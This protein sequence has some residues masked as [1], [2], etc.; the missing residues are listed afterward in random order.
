MPKYS[1]LTDWWFSGFTLFSGLQLL[2]PFLIRM[3]TIPGFPVGFPAGW[4]LSF[5]EQLLLGKS[6]AFQEAALSL[7][8]LAPA[9]SPV[10]PSSFQ[11]RIYLESKNSLPAV[12]FCFQGPF[13]CVLLACWFWLPGDTSLVFSSF[14]FPMLLAQI[15]SW[16]TSGYRILLPLPSMSLEEYWNYRCVLPSPAFCVFLRIWT[17]VLMLVQQMPYPLSISPAYHGLSRN[18]LFWDWQLKAGTFYTNPS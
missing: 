4:I 16:G 10:S 7:R 17:Q 12:H 2:L 8:A 3:L 11:E 14:S 13:T 5:L 6:E 18:L 1:L 15:A 9:V